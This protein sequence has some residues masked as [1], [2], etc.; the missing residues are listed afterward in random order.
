MNKVMLMG[1]LTRDPEL[2]Q[3]NTSQVPVASFAVAVDRRFQKDKEKVTDF[4]N[5]VAW[6]GTAEFV[7]KNF[8]KGQPIAIDGRLQLNKWTDADGNTRYSVEV[9][10]ESVH[11]AG[12]KTEDGHRDSGYDDDFDP[13]ASAQAQDAATGDELPIAA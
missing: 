5:V 2:R 6:N 9:I 8:T 12:F 13:F 4:F 3:T 10:A 11:F 7:H 1:R